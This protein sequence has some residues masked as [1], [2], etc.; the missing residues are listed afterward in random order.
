[1]GGAGGV[2]A[3]LHAWRIRITGSR[4]SVFGQRGQCHRQDLDVVGG[5]VGPGLAGTQQAGQCLPTGD[6][7][8]V[9]VG[10]QRME[11][12]GL[13]PRF[14]A[15]SFSLCAM[16]IVASISI[17][18]PPVMSGPAPAAH[19][20][21]RARTHLPQPGQVL[22]IDAVEYPPRGGVTGD[23]TEQ[24][25]LIP[26]SRQMSQRVTAVGDHHRRIRQHSPRQV[27]RQPPCRCQEA[28]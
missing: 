19:A 20:R 4:P 12:E 6:I 8:T 23:R 7:G 26:Q 14:A 28:P 17:T 3:D 5:G 9:E 15:F 24:F 27:N 2:G 22:V 11:P 10:Q 16:E 18:S 13:L 1:M 25:V 21:S